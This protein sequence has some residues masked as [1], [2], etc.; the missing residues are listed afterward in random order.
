MNKFLAKLIKNPFFVN[1][2][3]M[4]AVLLLVLFGTLKWLSHYTRHNEVVLVPDVK[5]LTIEDAASFFENNGL[6]Y[7]IIDSVFSKDVA[8]GTIVELTPNVGSKVKEGRIVFVTLNALTS[9]VETIPDVEDMSF[10]QAY[11]LL[12]ARGFDAVE[13]KYVP[14]DFKDLAIAVELRGRV[15]KAGEKVPLTSPLVL[16][17]S[18]GE[19]ELLEDSLNLEE[20]VKPLNSEDENWF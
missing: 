4:L 6:R 20:P 19:D 17:V 1:F 8:P 18:N 10:R 9:Q 11:A 13:I 3:L 12:R 16:K 15:L 7:H 2:L 14:G 5:G